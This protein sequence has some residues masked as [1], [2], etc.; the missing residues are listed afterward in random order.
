MNI[1]ASTRLVKDDVE[2]LRLYSYDDTVAHPCDASFWKGIVTDDNGAIVA[3]SY[4]WS[5]TVVV[6]DPEQL[7]VAAEYSPLYDRPG[8]Q[9]VAVHREC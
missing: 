4:P 1:P 5:P 8:N 7:P 9:G 3:R 2:G 6:E